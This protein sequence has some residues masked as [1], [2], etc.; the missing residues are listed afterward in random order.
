MSSPSNRDRGGAVSPLVRN[1]L[2]AVVAAGVALGPA[3]AYSKAPAEGSFTAVDFAWRANATSATSL[4]IAPGGTVTFGYPEGSSFHNLHF[5]GAK[6]T[7]EGITAGPRPAPWQGEC[8]FTAVGTYPFI[9]DV[10]DTMSGSVVVGTAP[11][12]TPTPTSTPGPSATPGAT[13]TPGPEST[14]TPPGTTSTPT[15]TTLTVKLAPKQRGTRIRGTVDVR[16]GASK[17]EVTLTARLSKAR[18]RVGRLLKPTTARGAV[19]FSVPLD[20]K[21]R[22]HL[23]ARRSLVVTVAVALTPPGGKKVTR[24]MKATIRPR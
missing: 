24:S 8:T 18:V 5:T 15:Q 4:T 23:R 3:L 19:A 14:A 21:A 13:A 6:P 17:L 9:C 20:A 11:T 10:H 22:R 16:Q 2:I 1:V 7:C 12:P